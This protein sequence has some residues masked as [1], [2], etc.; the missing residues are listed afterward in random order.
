MT[1]LILNQRMIAESVQVAMDAQGEW[2]TGLCESQ[3]SSDLLSLVF[4]DII[5][6]VVR[7]IFV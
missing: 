1:D 5:D 6:S 3:I 2:T 4:E 7:F